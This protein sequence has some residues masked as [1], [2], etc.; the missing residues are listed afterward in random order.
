MIIFI[1]GMCIVLIAIYLFSCAIVSSQSSVLD[2]PIR[3]PVPIVENQ[4][5]TNK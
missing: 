3:V 5:E 1:I 4:E 2:E